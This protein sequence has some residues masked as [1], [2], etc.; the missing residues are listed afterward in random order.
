MC[1]V[2]PQQTAGPKA[3]GAIRQGYRRFREAPIWVVPV[4]FPDLRGIK[5]NATL[6]FDLVSGSI[7]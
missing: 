7:E 2:L 4:A 1:S 5:S 3:M 6:E